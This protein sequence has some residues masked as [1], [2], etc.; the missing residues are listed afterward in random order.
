MWMD[1]A[2]EYRGAGM[3]TRSTRTPLWDAEQMEQECVGAFVA[4]GW[5]WE[6]SAVETKSVSRIRSSANARSFPLLWRS[7]TRKLLPHIQDCANP[8]IFPNP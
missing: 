5:T 3:Y 6:I 7:N 8:I 2:L 4:A 1:S